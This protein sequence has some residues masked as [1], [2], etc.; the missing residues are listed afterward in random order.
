MASFFKNVV[1]FGAAGRIEAEYERL[2]EDQR[3]L[4]E[5]HQRTEAQRLRVNA[6]L[7]RLVETKIE[8]LQALRRVR[9]VSESLFA[10]DRHLGEAQVGEVQPVVADFERVEKTLTAGETALNAAKGVGTGVSTAAGA[11]ALASTFGAASTGTSLSALTGAALTKATLAWFGGGAIA[12]GGGGMVA[13][14]TVL[15]GM[16]ALPAVALLAVFSHASA[17]KKIAALKEQGLRLIEAQEECRK[18]EVV[19]DVTHQRAE[20]LTQ[21]IHAGQRAFE[22]ELHVVKQR[23]Y[24]WGILSRLLMRVR[25]LFTGRAFRKTDLEEV[26]RLG[27]AATCFAR[28]LDLKVFDTQGEV[29]KGDVP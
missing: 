5:L 25:K 15:G 22:H 20:E 7:E 10:R 4:E 19:L 8:G 27:Q 11:W 29:V 28:I 18:L 3:E 17:S 12:A 13:G 16:V 24:P 14:M 6:R 26:A 9:E 21:A 2:L 1:T 23:I